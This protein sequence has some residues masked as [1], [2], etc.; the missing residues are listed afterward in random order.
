MGPRT[1]LVGQIKRHLQVIVA[2]VVFIVVINRAIG[3][4]WMQKQLITGVF[5]L[6]KK[7]KKAT[8]NVLLFCYDDCLIV[9]DRTS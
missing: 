1:R 4:N 8:R 9:N 3:Q 5:S 2:N 7:N 6:Y